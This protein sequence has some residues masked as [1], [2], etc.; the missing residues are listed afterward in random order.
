MS[1]LPLLGHLIAGG[2]TFVLFWATVLT[3]K[4]SSSHRRRGKLFFISLLPVG[5]S[6][7]AILIL[8]SNTF[9]PA[10][11]V[12]FTYLLL[13][14]STVGTVGWTA[15]RWKLIPDALAA[16]IS[17]CRV[18]APIVKTQAKSTAAGSTRYI[19]SGSAYR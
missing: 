17:E 7:G 10:R 9:D 3:V 14:L 19:D 2:L 11:M 15:I 4:G 6:V 8:R 16:V 18:S 13:C 1:N 12:Q 5:V